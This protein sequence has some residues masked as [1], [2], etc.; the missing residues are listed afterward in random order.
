[1]VSK[2][3][4]HDITLI[5]YI[6]LE[7]VIRYKKCEPFW[8]KNNFKLAVFLYYLNK[9]AQVKYV[10]KIF[11]DYLLIRRKKTEVRSSSG[12]TQKFL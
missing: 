12:S 10:N 4:M 7:A 8:K 2:L 1:M 11:V 9:G 3:Q 5:I 6:F